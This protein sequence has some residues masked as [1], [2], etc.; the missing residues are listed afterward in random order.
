MLGNKEDVIIED[1]SQVLSSLHLCL[2]DSNILVQRAS[3]ELLATRDLGKG[4]ELIKAA[5][6]TLLRR[7]TSLNRLEF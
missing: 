1:M 6:R 2:G 7:D 3:L 5:L 4:L